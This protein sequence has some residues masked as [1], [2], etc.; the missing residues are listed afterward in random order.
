[1]N[2]NLY[3]LKHF[4]LPAALFVLTVFVAVFVQQSRDWLLPVMFLLLPFIDFFWRMPH[5]RWK[6]QFVIRWVILA[7]IISTLLFLHTEVLDLFTI[8]VL[9]A[10]LPEEWFFRAYLQKRLGNNIAAVFIVSLLF[11]WMHYL[12]HDSVVVWLVFI[13]SVFFGWIYK[14][15]DDLILVVLLHALSN[16]VYY[17]Y[18]ETYVTQ[19]FIG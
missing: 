16:L 4:L 17:I 13:P 14:K 1:M 9:V 11:S 3:T 10:A 5:L 18:F 2:F 15:T 12:T 6:Q 19:F 8:M 7:V